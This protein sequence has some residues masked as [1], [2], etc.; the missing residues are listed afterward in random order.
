MSLVYVR[1]G[2][3]KSKLVYY[4]GFLHMHIVIFIVKKRIGNAPKVKIW[5]AKG[6]IHVVNEN[7]LKFTK[8][9]NHW[10]YTSK[11]DVK[12][13]VLHLKE[14]SSQITLSRYTLF[15]CYSRNVIA[16]RFCKIY[17]VISNIN[18]ALLFLYEF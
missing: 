12:K 13:A 10:P 6:R 8:Y 15:C 5:N 1:S 16:A 18:I 9:H 7:V 17:C 4:E 14:I 11:I 3:N 2:K